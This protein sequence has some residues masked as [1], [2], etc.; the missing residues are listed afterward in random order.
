M[1]SD[2]ISSDIENVEHYLGGLFQL[3]VGVSIADTQ[4]IVCG[5]LGYEIPDKEH[6]TRTA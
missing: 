3:P 4:D 5:A 6:L 1:E 2:Y